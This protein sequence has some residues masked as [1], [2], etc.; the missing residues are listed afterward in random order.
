[1]QTALRPYTTAGVALVGASV[2]AISPVAAPTAAIEKVRDTAVELSALVNPIEAFGPVFEA[3]VADLQALGEVI[4]AN[5][6]P[7]LSQILVNQINGVGNIG[8]ALEAQIGVIP[9]LPDLLGQ[10]VANELGAFGDLAGVGQ[11][12]VQNLT[13]VLT[14][15]EPGTVQGQLQEALDLLNQGEFGLAFQ[16]LAVLPLLP[17]LG[18]GLSNIE[19]LPPLIQALQQPLADAA[20]LFPIAA[21]PLANAQAALGVLGNPLNALI[22]GVGALTAVSGVAD[23]A[24]NT[25]GGLIEAV[26]NGDPEAAF[27]TIITQAAKGTQALVDGA[28]AP[29]FG[30]IAGLQGL[31]EAIAAAITTPSFPPQA[32]VAEVAKVPSA[33]AQSFTLTAP[34]E[35]APESTTD[36]TP[37]AEK[38]ESGPVETDSG[39]GRGHAVVER[40]TFG[41]RQGQVHQR[42]SVHPRVHCHKGRPPSRGH[43][44]RLRAESQGCS[45]EDHQGA[46]RHWWR[47]E[48]ERHCVHERRRKRFEQCDFRQR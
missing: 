21:G 26:Q 46:H 34:L 28:F 23:A 18:N 39:T 17:L 14:G 36:T 15:S 5:P 30:L 31:R 3:T 19:L 45:P 25:V 9:Q 35:K 44:T 47:Q 33:Q 7:I 12:F 1:M 43:R 20:A 32:A 42:Q 22:I 38:T 4:G 29:Q 27:N 16:F 41:E 37:A 10:T 13:D 8:A 24:G 6:T 40:N 11:A 2:I 48:L